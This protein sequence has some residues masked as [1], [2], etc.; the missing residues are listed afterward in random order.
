[1]A[2]CK[3]ACSQLEE[4]KFDMQGMFIGHQNFYNENQIRDNLFLVLIFLE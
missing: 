2:D 4:H 3:R 1:M